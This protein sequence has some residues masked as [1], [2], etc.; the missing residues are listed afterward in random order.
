MPEK[1]MEL[2]A[3]FEAVSSNVS[4]RQEAMTSS[5]LNHLDM[6]NRECKDHHIFFLIANQQAASCTFAS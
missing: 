1:S 4:K 6:I 3:F 5:F 2:P